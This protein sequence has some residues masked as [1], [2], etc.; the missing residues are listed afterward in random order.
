MNKLL[1]GTEQADYDL[2]TGVYLKIDGTATT[3]TVLETSIFSS[4]IQL[5]A[6]V[7]AAQQLVGGEELQIDV[8][9]TSIITGDKCP[10]PAYLVNIAV[11]QTFVLI[12]IPP[13]LVITG[14]VIEIKAASDASGDDTVGGS[15]ESVLLGVEL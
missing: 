1:L 12:E 8:Y 6:T 10:M 13:F 15:V 11:G 7:V 14:D 2:Y 3:Y 9:V 5:G 4:R